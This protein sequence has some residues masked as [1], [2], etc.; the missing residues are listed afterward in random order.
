MFSLF[1]KSLTEMLIRVLALVLSWAPSSL[2]EVTAT[3]AQHPTS[4]QLTGPAHLQAPK[5]SSGMARSW[6]IQCLLLINL[7]CGWWGGGVGGVEG[8]LLKAV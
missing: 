5:I 2:T 6:Q 4:R 8:N 3:S 7:Y 1:L